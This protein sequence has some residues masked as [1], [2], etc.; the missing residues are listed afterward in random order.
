M[1]LEELNSVSDLTIPLFALYLLVFCNFT[2][3][4]MG[5]RLSNVLD[6]NMYAKHFISFLLLFFLV[7][8]IDPENSEKSILINFGLTIVIYMLY[9]MTTR[10]SFPIMIILLIITMII[11]ILSK[12]AKKKLEEKK[13]DEYNN[14]KLTQN[15]LFIIFIILGGIGFSLYFYEK[16]M[17]Y[18]G[19]FSILKFIFGNP[20]C[21][22]YTPDNAKII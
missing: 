20:V 22:K 5:C 19:K 4:T 15:I 21:R 10:V 7:I 14:L 16:Y 18:K 2:K 1:A 6:N 11:Y 9:M 12:L 3:E 13:E 17:E 8:I